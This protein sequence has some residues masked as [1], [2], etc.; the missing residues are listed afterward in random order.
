VKRE[1]VVDMVEFGIVDSL[2]IV[3]MYQQDAVTL[4]GL[5]LTKEA[6]IHKEKT[7]TLY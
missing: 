1:K 7:Y 4:A 5:L 2:Q 6:V 3:Q